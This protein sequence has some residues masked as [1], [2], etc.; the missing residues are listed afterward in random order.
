MCKASMVCEPSFTMM[1]SWIAPWLLPGM[2]HIRPLSTVAVSS[3]TQRLKLSQ[4]LAE[5]Y[6]SLVLVHLILVPGHGGIRARS[7]IDHNVEVKDNIVAVLPCGGLRL[8]Q[9]SAHCLE[10]LVQ[11]AFVDARREQRRPHDLRGVFHRPPVVT[12]G[13]PERAS[14]VPTIQH[15]FAGAGLGLLFRF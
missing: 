14:A 4:L 2:N 5:G 1:C 13:L 9:N 11:W 3:E 12:L 6:I 15:T 8:H 7:L 10:S